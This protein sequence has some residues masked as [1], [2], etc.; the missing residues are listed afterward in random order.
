MH[1]IPIAC[2]DAAHMHY[3]HMSKEVWAHIRVAL[4]DDMGPDEVLVSVGLTGALV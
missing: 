1:T 3:S 4:V 2:K